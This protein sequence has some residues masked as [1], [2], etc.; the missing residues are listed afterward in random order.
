MAQ[1]KQ[2][3]IKLLV[4]VSALMAFGL[5]YGDCIFTRLM[6]AWITITHGVPAI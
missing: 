1:G 4:L 6:S 5:V 2:R 3:T